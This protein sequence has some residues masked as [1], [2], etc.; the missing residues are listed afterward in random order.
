M[1]RLVI[2]TLVA[3]C[4]TYALA[5]VSS[6]HKAPPQQQQAAATPRIAYVWGG[7]HGSS[8]ISVINADGTGETRLTN[9]GLNDS[10]PTWSPDGTEIGF[11]SDRNH[12]RPNIFRMK[13]DGTGQT[14][15]TN[16]SDESY[17]EPDWSPDAQNFV[18]TSNRGGWRRS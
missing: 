8:E 17:F 15:V 3:V 13:A 11:A 16:S 1:R 2:I 5:G 10:S 9:D 14:P 12:G 6:A 18:C 4:A 7:G